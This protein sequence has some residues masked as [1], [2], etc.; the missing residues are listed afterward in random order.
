MS[1][2]PLGTRPYIVHDDNTGTNAPIVHQRII[3]RL[4]AELYPL[5]FREGVI[6][7]EPLPETMLGEIEICQT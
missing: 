4:T 7:L 1:Y 6:P 5:Y 2:A 3:A